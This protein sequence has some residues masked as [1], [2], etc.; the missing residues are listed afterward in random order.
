LRDDPI[1]FLLRSGVSA[2]PCADVAAWWPAFRETARTWRNP[3]D[4][5]IVAGFAADRVGWAFASGYQAALHALFP[6]PEDRICALCVTEEEGNTPRAIKTSLHD[7]KL[8]G[9][10]KW[11]TLGPDGA[12]FFVAARDEAASGE[13]SA[14]KIARVPSGSPGVSIEEMPPTRFVPEVPHAKLKFE[15]VAVAE[16]DLLA[17]DGYD[18]YV[19]PFRTVED[20]HVHAAILAY[21]VRE[22]RRLKWREAWIERA[23]ALLFSLQNLSVK[24][25]STPETHVAVAGALATGAGL[26]EESETYWKAAGADPTAKRWQR[27]RDLLKVAGGIR[28]QRTKRAWERLRPAG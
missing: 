24:D 12:L 25:P 19:R 2:A 14:I 28:E 4:R 7:H 18:L 27:D 1:G 9:A 15:N 22:A 6:A 21:L 17:G 10:K 11:A 13:R 5:A 20:L 3:M 26:I 23:L 16:D 8:N